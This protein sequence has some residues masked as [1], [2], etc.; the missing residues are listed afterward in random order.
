MLE[1]ILAFLVLL[2]RRS[3]SGKTT[4]RIPAQ[5]AFPPLTTLRIPAP[6]CRQGFSVGISVGNA[7]NTPLFIIPKVIARDDEI[8]I[9]VGDPTAVYPAMDVEFCWHWVAT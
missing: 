6:G 1:A 2:V 3:G 8:E 4:L 9:S 7:P 5:T